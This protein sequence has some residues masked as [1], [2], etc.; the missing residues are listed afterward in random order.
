MRPLVHTQTPHSTVELLF[1]RA[2]TET[3]A[4]SHE[5]RAL[6]KLQRV[7][8]S[9]CEGIS[10]EQGE[11]SENTMDLIGEDEFIARICE[12]PK[13]VLVE[14]LPSGDVVL[15]KS[16][17]KTDFLYLNRAFQDVLLDVSL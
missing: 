4:P 6:E 7:F 16:D 12:I 14:N 2:I 8:R 17:V 15:P 13:G 5:P 3:Y 10:E 1:L 11:V 9:F